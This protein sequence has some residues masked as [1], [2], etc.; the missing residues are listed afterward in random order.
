[1]SGFS[2]T[3]N[4]PIN[5]A[6]PPSLA[7][8]SAANT[9][10]LGYS[11]ISTTESFVNSPVAQPMTVNKMQA[12]TGTAPGPG[13]SQVWTL[14]KNGAD[15]AITC[16]ISDTNVAASDTAHSVSFVPGDKVDIKIVMSAGAATT[17]TVIA[18]LN[19]VTTPP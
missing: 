8:M 13:Q 19:A 2:G 11:G 1:M 18:S 16:T 7:A 17:N 14:R 12:V 6:H 5:L 4:A 10:F 9:Y 3:V 15:T